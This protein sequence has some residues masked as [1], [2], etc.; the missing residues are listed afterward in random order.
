MHASA[1]AFS[2]HPT[3]I[4]DSQYVI[5]E[6]LYLVIMMPVNTKYSINLILHKQHKTDQNMNFYSNFD[7]Q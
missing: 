3:I 5:A 7:T 6:N 1:Y 2:M 4:F